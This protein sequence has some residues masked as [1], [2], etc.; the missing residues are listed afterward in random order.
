MRRCEYLARKNKEPL[1]YGKGQLEMVECVEFID[2][3]ER[4]LPHL[5][6]PEIQQSKRLSTSRNYEIKR[7]LSFIND[8]IENLVARARCCES[9][10]LSAYLEEKPSEVIDELVPNDIIVQ[11]GSRVFQPNELIESQTAEPKHPVYEFVHS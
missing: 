7:N 2:E 3:D 8:A 1:A 11:C 9:E 10:V 5:V 4:C 6:H